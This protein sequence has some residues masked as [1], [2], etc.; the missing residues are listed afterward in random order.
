MNNSWQD[1]LNHFGKNDYAG[2]NFII[3][4]FTGEFDDWMMDMD[5]NISI[6][7]T[8]AAAAAAKL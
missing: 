8:T 3:T 4:R 5:N 7:W 6:I 1:E 2:H